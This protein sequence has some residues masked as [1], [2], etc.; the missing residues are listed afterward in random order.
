MLTVGHAGGCQLRI[1]GVTHRAVNNSY[2]GVLR[3]NPGAFDS[4]S[5]VGLWGSSGE[6]WDQ[7]SAEIKPGSDNEMIDFASGG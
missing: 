5:A 1:L 6:R 7:I 2:G 4:L 3:K